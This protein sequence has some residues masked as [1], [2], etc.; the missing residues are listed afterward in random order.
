MNDPAPRRFTLRRSVLALVAGVAVAVGSLA[1]RPVLAAEAPECLLPDPSKWPA[2][3]KPYFM[4]AFDT[5]GSMASGIATNNSCGYPNTRTGHGSCAVKNTFMAYAGQANFGLASY[6]R[7]MSNCGAGRYTG[8][9]YTN[10]PNNVQPASCAAGG[11]GPEPNAVA[12]S[13]TRAGANILVPML[14]DTTVPPPPSNVPQ[15]ISWVDNDCTGSTELFADGCTPLNGILRDM[16]RYYSVGWTYP[17][18]GGVNYPSPLTSLANGERA[19]RSVNVILVT[20]GDETCDNQADANAAAAALYAGFTKNGITW[21]VKTYVINFA[22]G[23]Q[24]NTNAIA[25][26]GGTTSS[27][28]ATN[29]QQLALALSNI[30]GGS[31]KPETCD[32]T[33]NG[34]TDNGIA[35][36][37]CGTVD[38]MAPWCAGTITCK[39]PQNVAIGACAPGGGFNAC[40]NA[41]KAETCNNI[42]DNCNGIIDDGIPSIPCVPAGAPAGLNYGPNST[43]KMG[44][45]A[46]TNGATVCN[47]WIGPSAEIC[48]GLANNCDGAVDN[49][50]PGTGNGY[51]TSAPV[52]VTLDKTPACSVPSKVPWFNVTGPEVEQTCTKMGGAICT[53]PEWQVACNANLSCKWGD[54][55]RG[56]ACTS[57]AKPDPPASPGKYC[58]LANTFDFDPVKAGDQDGLLVTG[59]PAL[60]QCFGDWSALLGNSVAN[61]KIYDITGNLREITRVAASTYELLG[62]AFDSQDENGSSCQFTFYTVDQSFK[63]YDTGFRCCFATDPTL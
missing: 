33:C 36:I 22:G 11:C 23:S 61:D 17:G 40:N 43:C 51:V 28:F 12:G 29:E 32:N 37:P 1:P 56:A 39:T 26:A 52:G 9:T 15:L 38:P 62:G 55:P 58:N 63:F 47:G 8:C 42:D 7:K 24:A 5:S 46:C 57:V 45:T 19:C 13:P 16:L 2:P 10:L 31:I 30:V 18:V 49:G 48:D 35:P 3:A 34:V 6:A 25:A 44:T 4:V 59:S 20:D 27:Y 54:A 21:N 60:S 53:P 50:V 14:N 41:P